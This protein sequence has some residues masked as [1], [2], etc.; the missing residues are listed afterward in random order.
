[1]RLLVPAIL[2]VFL[3]ACGSPYA[4][5]TEVDGDVHVHLHKLGDGERVAADSDS[6]HLRVRVARLGQE[7][8]SQF[9][10]QRMYAA[11]Q[12]RRTGF[13]VVMDRLHV[14]DSMSVIIAAG[15]VPWSVLGAAPLSNE[16]DTGMVRLELSVLEIITPEQMREREAR[17]RQ[18]DPGG[19]ERR[20]ITAW[21]QRDDRPWTRWGTSDLHYLITGSA[22]DTNAVR[23]G[24]QVTVSYKGLVLE[25][26]RVIDSTDKNGSTF[27]W[28]YGD[29]DQVVKGLEV[30]VRLMR[31]GQSGE[32]IFPSAY[33]F[34]ARG[35]PGILDPWSAM[36][37]TVKLERVQRKPHA[38]K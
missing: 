18:A 2:A 5:F 13:Q 8:G 10:T 20:L 31:E 6:V 34:G 25:D 7:P 29:P 38:G 33:A 26:G 36:R 1:M 12:L 21:V 4:G 17:Y 32:F 23:P 37:Y 16:Q 24:D 30:A 9:S 19:F 35:V 14:G 27:S 11:Y 3:V 28:T 22:V 15:R